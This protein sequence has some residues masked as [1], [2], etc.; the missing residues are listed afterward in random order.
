LEQIDS[1]RQTIDR[2]GEMLDRLMGLLGENAANGERAPMTRQ[3]GKRV[4]EEEQFT[5]GSDEE[6]RR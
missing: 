2:Q 1:L 4:S 3:K 5:L 6:D